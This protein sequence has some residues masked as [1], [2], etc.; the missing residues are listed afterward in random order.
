VIALTKTQI[1]DHFSAGRR[2]EVQRERW[3]RVKNEHPEAVLVMVT[4]SG[5]DRFRRACN[6]WH[7]CAMIGKCSSKRYGLYAT[8]D[9]IDIAKIN[10]SLRA[11]NGATGSADGPSPSVQTAPGHDGSPSVDAGPSCGAMPHSQRPGAE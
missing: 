5:G 7:R 11:P 1:D 9:P 10:E 3:E 4:H 8:W 2:R 6:R